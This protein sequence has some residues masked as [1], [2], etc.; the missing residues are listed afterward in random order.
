MAADLAGLCAPVVMLEM[1]AA[2]LA[3]ELSGDSPEE[4]AAGFMDELS[5]PR[6]RRTLLAE[7]PALARL[8]CDRTRLQTAAAV[9]LLER[10]ARDQERI[11]GELCGDDLGLLTGVTPLGDS[12]SGGRRVLGLRFHSG[13]ELVY[14]PR[15][16]AADAAW[17]RLLARLNDDGLEPR[18]RPPLS[19]VTGPEHGW[20]E[21]IS[22]RACDTPEAVGRYFLRL[23]AQL[24]LL[25]GM[26][27]VDFHQENVIACGE[28]PMIVDLEGLFHPRLGGVRADVV[29]PLVAETGMDCV[30]RVGLL[31]RADVAF[32]VDISGLGRDPGGRPSVKQA[33]LVGSGTD[34]ARL[35][36]RQVELTAEHNAVRL[37]S[38]L[39]RPADWLNE[40]SLGFSRAHRLLRRHRDELLGPGGA[41]AAFRDAE[42]RV[43]LRPTRA[44]AE[45]IREQ[46]TRPPALADGLARERVL[47]R[48][49][50]GAERRPELR[51]AAPAEHHDLWRGDVP[52]FTGRPG[53]GDVTHHALGAL[54]GMLAPF[55]FESV[56]CVRRLD[57]Q[58]E[59]R[60]L[61]FLR[62]SVLAAAV[63]P[64]RP[65]RRPESGPPPTRARLLA[66]AERCR[67]R[68]TVL[69]LS[70]GEAVGWLSPQPIAGQP[71]QVL[72]PA[73]PGLAEGQA[74]IALFLAHVGAW[75]SVRAALMLIPG[76][77]SERLGP[78]FA[79]G[80]GGIAWALARI[81]RLGADPALGERA[82]RLVLGTE[83]GET[84]ELRSGTAGPASAWR[85][86]WKR[87][88]RAPCAATRAPARHSWPTPAPRMA[89]EDWPPGT[90]GERW[91]FTGLGASWRTGGSSPAPRS[92]H[93]R[94]PSCWSRAETD[95]SSAGARERHWS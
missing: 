53:A 89:S 60:Q 84:T 30:L 40:L 48:L 45:L 51:D 20:Q 59:E 85:P 1:Q 50:R 37:G 4:R 67:R 86:H 66:A 22:P 76:E 79:D 54:P 31:P 25:H 77:P 43:I 71:G 38:R 75:D 14:K 92:S 39:V 23:G 47:N 13:A 36:E 26:R 15:S 69:A 63:H 88:G 7:N 70:D 34:A 33:S 93:P 61:A 18:A 83:P 58:D 28:H 78:G 6:R 16:L 49:W 9:E 3:G 11:A 94:R 52:K 80:A 10:L 57:E 27:A 81:A 21:Q 17:A 41:L 91:L 82:A 42:T 74:G 73:G 8:L 55:R 32:G 72:R 35:E 68:L 65:P 64:A 12:H 29:D 46:V 2:A 5:L 24:A 19:L 87:P 56:D 90:A 44:Y 62:C 95:P